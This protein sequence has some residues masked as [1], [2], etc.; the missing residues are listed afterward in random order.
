MRLSGEQRLGDNGHER[1]GSSHRGGPRL[2]GPSVD[3]LAALSLRRTGRHRG[4]PRR[5]LYPYTNN[6]SASEER[7]LA[8]RQPRRGGLGSIRRRGGPHRLENRP[9][10]QRETLSGPSRRAMEP[11]THLES[12]SEDNPDDDDEYDEY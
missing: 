10:A 4:G 12:E 9:R 8:Q 1:S 3:R 6:S 5:P 2:L 7:H 11:M